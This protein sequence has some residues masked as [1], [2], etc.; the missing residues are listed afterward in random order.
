[1]PHE[2]SLEVDGEPRPVVRYRG[3][4]FRDFHVQFSIGDVEIKSATL[5]NGLLEID[6]IRHIPEAKKARQIEI[7]PS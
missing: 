4:G 1:L 3:I 5:K 2:K 6:L 7:N